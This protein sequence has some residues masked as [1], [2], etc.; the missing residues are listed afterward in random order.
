MFNQ[1]SHTD[2]DGCIVTTHKWAMFVSVIRPDKTVKARFWCYPKKR[3]QSIL[4]TMMKAGNKAVFNVEI[5]RG[6]D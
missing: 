1:Y 5:Q 3:G 2:P 4:E 6:E